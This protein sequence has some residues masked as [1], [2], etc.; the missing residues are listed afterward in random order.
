MKILKVLNNNV[1]IVKKENGNEVIM[2]GSGLAFGKKRGDFVDKEKIEKIFTQTQEDKSLYKKLAETIERI[3]NEYIRITEKI[4]R[5]AEEKLEIKLNE[6]I[7]ISLSDHLYFAV[8]RFKE[9]QSL[10]NILLWEIKSSYKDEYRVGEEAL[11]IIQDEIDVLLP[12]DEAGF[13]AL[14]I[15]NAELNEDMMNVMIITKIIKEI[16][17]IVKYHFKVELEEESQTYYR[18]VVHLKFLA[19]RLLNNAPSFHSNDDELYNMVRTGFKE[20]FK[21]TVKIFEHMEKNYKYNF[22]KD[23]MVYLT[24]HIEKLRKEWN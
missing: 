19:Q 13:I 12:I 2:M 14:H 6:S 16:T 5:Y 21:C 10:K 17:S 18:F 3:P 20:S 8:K 23:E 1:V 11:K 24:I 7:F 15:V 9:E 22:S 4:V